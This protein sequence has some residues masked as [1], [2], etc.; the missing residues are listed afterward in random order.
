MT[1]LELLVASILK[2]L[3]LDPEKLRSQAFEVML[4]IRNISHSFARIEQKIDLLGFKLDRRAGDVAS[5]LR[6]D[7]WVPDAMYD[8][9]QAAKDSVDYFRSL[10]S[11]GSKN[12]D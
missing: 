4:L 11:R 6:D 8:A 12:G 5:T 10:E 9:S 7:E 2:A 1:G 3:K